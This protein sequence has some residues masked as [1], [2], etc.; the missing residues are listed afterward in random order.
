VKARPAS[1]AISLAVPTATRG[2]QPAPSVQVPPYR[3]S[4]LGHGAT[5]L[6]MPRHGVPLIA[7]NAVLRGGSAGD[8]PDKAGVA[9]LV[10]GLLEKGAGSRDAFAFSDAVENA[11][12][13]F[14][15]SAGVESIH[16]AGQ[17][18]ARDRE[19]MVA[20]LAD[21]IQRPRF[22]AAEFETL[23]AR[24]IEMIKATK[25]SDP[26]QF[27]P[28]Y[29]R[30]LLFQGHPFVMPLGGSERSLAAL[31]YDDVLQH[32][33]SRFGADRLTVVVAGDI[34]PPWLEDALARAFAAYPR[35]AAAAPAL[36]PP[37]RIAGR[38]VLLIDAPAS[39]QTYFWIGNVGVPRKFAARAALDIV[40]TLYGGRFTSILNTKLRIESGLS[41]GASSAFTR[42][43]VAGEFSIQSFAQTEHTARAVGIALETLAHLRRRSSITSSM[44]ASGRDYVLGQY[45]LRLETSGDW[46]RTLGD[47]DLYGLDR[48]YVEGYAD[49]L[50]RVGLRE[51]RAVI[52]QGWPTPQDVAIALIGDAARIRAAAATLGPL[53]EISLAAPDFWPR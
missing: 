40:N 16:I 50:Q 30:A 21:C 2:V 28:V 34:D 11:G 47:F 38:R 8:P 6:V 48:D 45:P 49:A 41:Y 37:K 25:D 43:S 22:D 53:T 51:A 46:A 26:S 12:G 18:L 33:H 13:S 4:L 36:V 23:R 19:L 39:E 35:A 9:S 3:R 10:A 31:G 32:A 5:L 15:A 20:L 17:F 44:L 1:A 42:G 52:E 7:F 14:N 29:G 24:R 27:L